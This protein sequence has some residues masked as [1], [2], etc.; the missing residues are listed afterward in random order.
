[1]YKA[2]HV[3]LI[4]SV[5]RYYKLSRLN[6]LTQYIFIRQKQLIKSHTDGR[7]VVKILSLFCNETTVTLLI[8]I[9]HGGRVQE[10]GH[11]TAVSLNRRVCQVSLQCSSS[12]TRI[13]HKQYSDKTR[14][15]CMLV[16]LIFTSKQRS[17]DHCRGSTFSGYLNLDPY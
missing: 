14:H 12:Y 11:I 15:G 17:L 4:I 8:V 16:T 1:M 7:S 6:I 5:S 10:T 9:S 3:L 13:W 2:V